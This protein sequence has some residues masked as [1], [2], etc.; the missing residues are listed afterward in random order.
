MSFSKKQVSDG[1]N[2]ARR[3]LVAQVLIDSLMC[4][5]KVFVVAASSWGRRRNAYQ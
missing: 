1:P 4:V 5:L 2:G 3:F